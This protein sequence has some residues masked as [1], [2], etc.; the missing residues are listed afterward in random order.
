MLCCEEEKNAEHLR[1]AN[2]KFIQITSQDHATQFDD[3]VITC[4]YD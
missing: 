4:S 2:L 3:Y 1:Q